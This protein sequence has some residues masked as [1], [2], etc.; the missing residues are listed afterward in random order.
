MILIFPALIAAVLGMFRGGRLRNLEALQLRHVWIPLSMLALQAI[1]VLFPIFREAESFDLGRWV[2]PGSYGL[3]AFFLFVNR[4]LPGI[5]L[6]LMGTALNLAVMLANGGYM[7]VTPEAL[8]RSGHTDRI[9][10]LADGR[11]YARPGKD[12]VLERN[13]SHL[14]PLSD[15]IGIPESLPFATH[16]SLGDVLIALGAA[17]FLYRA[18]LGV[19]GEIEEEVWARESQVLRSQG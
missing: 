16:F 12:V 11:A 6:L 3:L 19:C 8:E 10:I 5:K 14:Q 2:L 7:P 9:V 18:L 4:R 17:W 15:V 13:E 1:T